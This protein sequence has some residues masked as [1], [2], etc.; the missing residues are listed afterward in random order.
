MRSLQV[1]RLVALV[2]CIFFQLHSF[3][4]INKQHTDSQQFRAE[5]CNMHFVWL[6]M[7]NISHRLH[8]YSVWAHNWRCRIV[9]LQFC[10]YILLIFNFLRLICYELFVYGF[11][12]TSVHS[13][14]GTIIATF[15]VTGNK[16]LCWAENSCNEYVPTSLQLVWLRYQPGVMVTL[17]SW[18]T[19][20]LY[21]GLG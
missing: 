15:Y 4:G 7:L 14:W 8:I 18:S 1:L 16:S 5:H 13:L 12:S 20:L 10:D 17:W 11:S 21:V 3:Q 6:C 2:P 9:F 19:K